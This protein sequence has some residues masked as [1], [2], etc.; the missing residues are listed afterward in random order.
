M[1][2]GD[3][4]CVALLLDRQADAD[5]LDKNGKSPLHRASTKGHH[6]CVELLLDRH[7]NVNARDV[8]NEAPLHRASSNGHHQCIELLIDHG[9]D[10][11]LTD[12][13]HCVPSLF[14]SLLQ[15]QYLACISH[16]NVSLFVLIS[17][18]LNHQKRGKT[19]EQVA[20]TP[21]IARL[22]RDRGACHSR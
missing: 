1:R 20:K 5:A 21:E 15:P 19:P 6:Q 3:R 17:Q 11:Y 16:T 12:V 8:C 4:Q 22:I 2:S 14:R 18:S 7:A 13:R 9:A 10:K